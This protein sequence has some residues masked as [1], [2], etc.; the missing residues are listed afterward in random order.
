MMPLAFDGKDGHMP[1]NESSRGWAVPLLTC[2]AAVALTAAA[3]K[4][5]QKPSPPQP[6]AIGASAPDFRL[7]GVDG[8]T[9]TLD[10]FKQA[11]ALAVVFTAVHCPTAEVYEQRL[12]QLVDDYRGKGVAFAVI[13][14]NNA[15]ALRLDE[16]GYTDLGDSLEDMKIRAE[17]RK[18]NFPFLYDGETQEISRLYGPVA[19]PH[20]FLFDGERKLRYHGRID[21]NPREALA[22]VPDTRNALDAV[23]SGTPVPVERTPA[24]GCSV[25]W[26]D[27]AA[28]HDAEQAAFAKEPV[29]LEKLTV[30]QAKELRKNSSGK[31]LLVNFWA[32]WC[33]PCVE[34]FPDLQN[35]WRMYRKRPFQM[36][37]ITVNYPDEEK[38][39]RAFL[40][41]QKASTRNYIPAVM[42]PSSIVQ[43]FAPDWQGGVPY[44]MVIGPDGKV[45]YQTNGRI[46]IL[47]ARRTILA[48]FP[49]D[50]YVGQNAYWNY[51]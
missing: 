33:A 41:S 37:T 30:E 49:D 32:T 42:D 21:S 44:S 17:H 50:D 36:V 46:D 14:P 47:H 43:A 1:A 5:T 51:R 2:A 25:K 34:E 7:Q 8:T 18:F 4:T 23:L 26:L 20:V 31:T 27:K 38:A 13:Q 28:S 3:V 40:E 29:P 11:K 19:T 10:S 48:S 35:T 39:V 6:L 22:K 9:Y 15:K 12:K 16:M 24:I 45:L